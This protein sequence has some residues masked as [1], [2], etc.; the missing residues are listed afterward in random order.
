MTV[1]KVAQKKLQIVSLEGN[2]IKISPQSKPLTN[3]E[4]LRVPIVEAYPDE[5]QLVKAAKKPEIFSQS[6]ARI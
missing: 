6:E 1:R 5:L 3:V 4:T 2:Q